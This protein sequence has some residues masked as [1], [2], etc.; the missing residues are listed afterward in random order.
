MGMRLGGQSHL[1]LNAMALG[2]QLPEHFYFRHMYGG[3]AGGK[4]RFAS[5]RLPHFRQRR[6]GRRLK[7]YQKGR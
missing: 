5:P 7:G 1:A 2:L 4:Q 3:L 6:H